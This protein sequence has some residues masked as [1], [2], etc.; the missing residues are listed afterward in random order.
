MN[1][2]STHYGVK[3]VIL[4]KTQQGYHPKPLDRIRG[5]LL[6]RISLKH[7]QKCCDSNTLWVGGSGIR[8]F[9]PILTP[10][11]DLLAEMNETKRRPQDQ[12]WLGFRYIIQKLTTIGASVDFPD[13]VERKGNKKSILKNG[14]PEFVHRGTS[15]TLQ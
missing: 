3:E 15:H 6:S 2:G 13:G 4:G 8:D 11:D 5:E 12:W 14:I 7:L 1:A 10:I 9:L